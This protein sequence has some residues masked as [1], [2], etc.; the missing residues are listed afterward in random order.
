M[1]VEGPAGRRY[2]PGDRCW[3]LGQGGGGNGGGEKWLDSGCTG[4]MG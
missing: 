3:C 1:K 4:E 2:N